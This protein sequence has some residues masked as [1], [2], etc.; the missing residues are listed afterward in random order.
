MMRGRVDV[1]MLTLVFRDLLDSQDSP[2]QTA[3][4]ERG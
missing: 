1:V 3:R 2:A 4:R